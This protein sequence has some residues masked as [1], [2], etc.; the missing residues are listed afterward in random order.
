M[1]KFSENRQKRI[2]NICD[3]IDHLKELKKTTMNFDE[4]KM[5][6]ERINALHSML[7]D[8]SKE[9]ATVISDHS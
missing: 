1:S 6:Q 9:S 7:V 5:L 2:N 4:D 8:I 3:N